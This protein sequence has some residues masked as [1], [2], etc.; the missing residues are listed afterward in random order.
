M[1]RRSADK[2]LDI[3][4]RLGRHAEITTRLR[5]M[6]RECEALRDQGKTAEARKLFT[7]IEGLHAELRELEG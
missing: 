5:A 4:Q 7:K 2:P 6:I 3:S 1:P